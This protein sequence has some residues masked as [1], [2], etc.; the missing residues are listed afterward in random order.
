MASTSTALVAVNPSDGTGTPSPTEEE[1]ELPMDLTQ[2]PAI[3]ITKSLLLVNNFV[4]NT[5]RFLNHFAHECEERINKVSTNLTRVE[6]LLAILEAKPNSIPDLTVSDSDVQVAAEQVGASTATPTDADAIGSNIAID[7]VD[8]PD[9]NA[10][11]IP[12][13]PPPPPPPSDGDAAGGL[14]PPPPPPPPPPAGDSSALVLAPANELAPAGDA[15]AS[16]APA[17]LKFKDDPVYAKYFTMKRLGMPD[18]AIVQKMAMDGLDPQLWNLDPEGPSPSAGGGASAPA[19]SGGPPPPPPPPPIQTNDLPL[20]PPPPPMS[21]AF[22]PASSTSSRG[23]GRPES[24]FGD[25]PPPPPPLPP[26]P[27]HPPS[28]SSD[29]DDDDAGGLFGGPPLPPGP[30]PGP[31]SGPPPGAPPAAPPP[32]PAEAPVEESG[33][34]LKL[35]DDPAFAKYFNMRKLGL[36][37]GAIRQKLMMDGVTLDILSMDPEGPSPNAGG[38]APSAAAPPAP[39]AGPTGLPP[40]PMPTRPGLPP[41]PFAPVDGPPLPPRPGLPPPPIPKYDDDSDFSD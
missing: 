33:G 23:S 28:D 10:G 9:T 16:E 18:G 26:L 17:V 37:D 39:P 21:E 31:P 7:S 34:F 3:P 4:S 2:L 27:P 20:P 32:P 15:A 25:G 13:P 5:T 12:P 29:D 19:S 14:I 30:P 24:L 40:P 35:K 38:G 41:P 22:S 6:I 1:V 36:P 8:L 11:I